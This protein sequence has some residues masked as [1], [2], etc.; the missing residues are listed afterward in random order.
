MQQRWHRRPTWGGMIAMVATR[1]LLHAGNCRTGLLQEEN[2]KLQH[3]F[4]IRCDTT[5]VLRKGPAD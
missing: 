2:L 4:L 1:Y 3:G 5:P